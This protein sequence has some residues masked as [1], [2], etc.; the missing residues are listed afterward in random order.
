MVDW[1]IT[2][3]EVI[4]DF[5]LYLNTK[6]NKFVLKGGTS[7]MMCYNLTRFSEDIDLD[8]SDKNTFFSI[9]D[10]FVNDFSQKYNGINYRRAK[11]TDTVKRV[12]IHY[13]GDKPLKVEVS[14]RKKTIDI[15]DCCIL[16][17][18][19]VYNIDAIMFMKLNA[20]NS[21]DK[22][23]DLYDV[24]FIYLNYKQNL[25]HQSIMSLRN[26]LEYRG[27]E[28]FDYL[29]NNQSDNLINNNELSENFL[30]M[31]YDLGLT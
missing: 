12:F 3:G 8:G 1:R 2:H 14:Y 17:G 26:S 9:I 24:T 20:F 11:D 23:R 10:C 25:S 16:N 31:Y 28:Q 4:K 6:S 19:L 30:T 22:I 5:L 13:G 18:I 15:N 29:V 7:L 27:I 21:R